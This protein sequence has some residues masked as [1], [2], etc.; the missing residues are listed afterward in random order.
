[1]LSISCPCC[2]LDV[3]GRPRCWL[4]SRLHDQALHLSSCI[5]S[6]PTSFESYPPPSWGCVCE[7]G[8][9]ADRMGRRLPPPF[10]PIRRGVSG[11]G[12]VCAVGPS[13]QSQQGRRQRSTR[14]RR[15]RRRI[16]HGFVYVAQ[17]QSECR[18]DG[19]ASFPPHEPASSQRA[20]RRAAHQPRTQRDREDARRRR[21]WCV[22]R[23]QRRVR[24]ERRWETEEADGAERNE[25]D[26]RRGRKRKAN[27]RD[28]DPCDV[29]RRRNERKGKVERKRMIRRRRWNREKGRVRT[30]I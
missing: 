14:R 26:G 29:D 28:V 3:D 19:T 15:R 25:E 22:K 30:W 23:R 6:H 20:R 7:W 24:F 17:P 10:P 4:G 2:T 16:R 21:R 12:C 27:E 13:L 1:M 18:T 8:A 5:S 11:G 9:A